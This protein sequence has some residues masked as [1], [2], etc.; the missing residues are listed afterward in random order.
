MIKVFNK[1]IKEGVKG[2][3]P[4]IYSLNDPNI[5]AIRKEDNDGNKR[6]FLQQKSAQGK[7]LDVSEGGYSNIKY[8]S[9][10]LGYTTDGEKEKESTKP[11]EKGQKGIGF[12]G[13]LPKPQLP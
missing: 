2:D 12:A 8:L 13:A 10:V 5:Q 4:I 3:T 1:T 6:W 11:L 7:F 9:D